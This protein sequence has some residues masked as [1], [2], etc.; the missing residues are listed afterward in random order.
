MSESATNSPFKQICP[1]SP[2]NKKLKQKI[3]AKAY[4]IL[5]GD[6]NK[7]SVSEN[8]D[9]TPKSA[10]SKKVTFEKKASMFGPVVE[11]PKKKQTLKSFLFGSNK[12]AQRKL[13]LFESFEEEDSTDQEIQKRLEKSI[14]K[15]ETVL[16][17]NCTELNFSETM[18]RGANRHHFKKFCKTERNMENVEFWEQIQYKYKKLK[19]KDQRLILANNLFYS[20][21]DPNSHSA[22]NINM[23]I[24]NKIKNR[25]E[26]AKTDSSDKLVDLFDSLQM[27]IE[28]V[29]LDAFQRFQLS[30]EY[31]KM[32]EAK[33]EREDKLES[34]MKIVRRGSC[35]F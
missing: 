24:V 17:S 4:K 26:K 13:K 22:L 8:Q 34:Q 16:Q 18:S 33:K 28:N 2:V 35:R 11:S 7:K 30:P 23:R 1:N 3:P 27:E 29:M 10:N 5:V 20:Y 9:K 14:F 12:P 31:E 32:L 25:I 19:N 21:V 6:P 15:R